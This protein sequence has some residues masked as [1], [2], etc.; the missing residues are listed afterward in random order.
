MMVFFLLMKI[1]SGFL[2]KYESLIAKIHLFDSVHVWLYLLT[3]S[4]LDFNVLVIPTMHFGLGVT[5]DLCPFAL[6]TFFK[7]GVCKLNYRGR[8][9]GKSFF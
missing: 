2:N 7:I 8:I 4:K 6:T 3:V 5:Y 1:R 9:L